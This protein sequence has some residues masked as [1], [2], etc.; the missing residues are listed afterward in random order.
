LHRAAGYILGVDPREEPP[1]IAL[2]DERRSILRSYRRA[3]HAPPNIEQSHRLGRDRAR[4]KESG[5]GPV[6]T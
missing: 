4:L 5:C 1:R 6:S 2:A 3:E